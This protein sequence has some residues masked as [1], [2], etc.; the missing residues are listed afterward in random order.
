MDLGLHVLLYISQAIFDRRIAVLMF[1]A[2]IV[3]T[4]SNDVILCPFAAETFLLDAA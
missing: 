1:F 4:P 2:V 3:M